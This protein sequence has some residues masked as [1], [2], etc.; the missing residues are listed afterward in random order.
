[1]LEC[2]LGRYPRF[3]IVTE[4]SGKEVVTG[5]GHVVFELVGKSVVSRRGGEEIEVRVNNSREERTTGK[6]N[7]E[8][9]T[10]RDLARG[11]DCHFGQV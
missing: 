6:T 2:L 10:A 8:P 5:L 11:R 7:D 3:G 1:M 9:E 4:E